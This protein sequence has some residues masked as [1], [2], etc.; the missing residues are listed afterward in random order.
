M[1]D[2]HNENIAAQD[3]GLAFLHASLP[4]CTPVAVIDCDPFQ[5]PDNVSDD[6]GVIGQVFR[7]V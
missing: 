7:C 1:G 3:P 2:Q 5:T 4:T 6:T